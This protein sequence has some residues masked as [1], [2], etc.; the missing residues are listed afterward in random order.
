METTNNNAITIEVNVA[1]P[2]GKVWEL[3]NEPRHITQWAFATDTW[4]APYAEN[5]IRTGGAFKTTMAA[6][7]GSFS[8]DFEGV[9]SL[10][11]NHELIEYTM[12]DARKVSIVFSQETNATR[13]VQTFDPESENPREM[14]K[15][16][17]QAILN[18]FKKYAESL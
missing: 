1:V 14:Q 12:P 11:K 17:W 18:N 3:W 9:Y 10:V 6:K 16:G 7:D 15:E 5:D 2:V 8:F 4:H 13:I